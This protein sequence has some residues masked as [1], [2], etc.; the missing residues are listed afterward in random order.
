[1]G[2]SSSRIFELTARQKKKKKKKKV[3]KNL[4]KNKTSREITI[5]KKV[6]EYFQVKNTDIAKDQDNHKTKVEDES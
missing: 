2:K 3:L 1:M 6:K 4:K 5:E